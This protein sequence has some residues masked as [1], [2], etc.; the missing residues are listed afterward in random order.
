MDCQR[1]IPVGRRTLLSQGFFM[2]E[3]LQENATLIVLGMLLLF[4][5]WIFAVSKKRRT[6]ADDF[7]GQAHT[8]AEASKLHMAAVEEKLDRIIELLQRDH[9]PPG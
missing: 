3:L 4:Y 1:N 7:M 9:P 8:H 6:K 5:L 2:L